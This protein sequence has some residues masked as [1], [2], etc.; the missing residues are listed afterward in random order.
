MK[1]KIKIKIIRP[2]KKNRQKK[3]RAFNHCYQLIY[4]ENKKTPK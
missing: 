3:K 2:K 4:G 1:K